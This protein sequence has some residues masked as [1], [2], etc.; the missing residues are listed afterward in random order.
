MAT[1]ENN[2]IVHEQGQIYRL[3]REERSFMQETHNQ[4]E[5][6]IK[7]IAGLDI[8]EFQAM[9]K[10]SLSV[11]E[12]VNIKKELFIKST[13]KA[14][15]IFD[16]QKLQHFTLAIAN[17]NDRLIHGSLYVSPDNGL[18]ASTIHKMEIENGKLEILDCQKRLRF[19]KVEIW[20]QTGDKGLVFL[21]GEK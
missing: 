7:E 8:G 5:L 17:P 19:V 11:N 16:I 12:Y 3:Q 1:H 20:G 13:G 21:Q 9:T 15:I 18:Y 14:H 2:R 6:R 10:G 4:T